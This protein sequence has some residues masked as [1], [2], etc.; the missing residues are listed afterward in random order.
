MYKHDFV[1]Y[2]IDETIST[3]VGSTVPLVIKNCTHSTAK[4]DEMSV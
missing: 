4:L 1:A 2:I 3:Q